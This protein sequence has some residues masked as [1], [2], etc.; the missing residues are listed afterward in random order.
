MTGNVLRFDDARI[1]NRRFTCVEH[2]GMCCR[3][4]RIPLFLK[5]VERIE[6]FVGVPREHFVERVED[7]DTARIIYHRQGGKDLSLTVLKTKNNGSCIFLDELTVKCTI[8][9]ARPVACR[10][11]PLRFYKKSDAVVEIVLDPMS[12]MFCGWNLPEGRTFIED[13]YLELWKELREGFSSQKR[14]DD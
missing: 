12:E 11:Y 10:L 2:C 8:Y 5:D 6:T 1:R 14:D 3:L 4:F 7:L 9:E 13:D